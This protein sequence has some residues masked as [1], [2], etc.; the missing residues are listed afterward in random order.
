M[1][2]F[3]CRMVPVLFQTR[4]LAKEGDHLL[5]SFAPGKVREQMGFACPYFLGIFLHSLQ[6]SPDIRGEI[7]LVDQ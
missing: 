6:I 2:A 3:Y 4:L 7:S 1:R 5:H